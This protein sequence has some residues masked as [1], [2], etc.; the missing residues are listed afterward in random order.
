[1][2]TGNAGSTGSSSTRGSLGTSSRDSPLALPWR[3][4]PL[5]AVVPHRRRAHPLEPV[6]QA[7]SDR[8]RILS[9]VVLTPYPVLSLKVGGRSRG[10]TSTSLLIRARLATPICGRT[11]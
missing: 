2:A 1:M 8:R 3:C 11:V 7:Y 10:Q 5:D 4:S 6:R 9:S